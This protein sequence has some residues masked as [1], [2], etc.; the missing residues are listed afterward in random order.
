[1]PQSGSGKNHEKLS[2]RKLTIRCFLYPG[3]SFFTPSWMQLSSNASYTI[4]LSQD[5]TRAAPLGY[6]RDIVSM[7]P[8][9]LSD[10]LR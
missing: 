4:A 6:G 10:G 8:G 3:R 7:V 9:F 1:M 5:G 2:C